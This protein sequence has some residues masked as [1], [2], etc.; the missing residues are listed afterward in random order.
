[1]ADEEMQERIS[2]FL[3]QHNTLTLASLHEGN[4]WACAV[5][6]CH[7]ET[8]NLYFISESKTW[9]AQDISAHPEVAVTIHGDVKSW[10]DIQ[11]LQ[12]TGRASLVPIDKRKEVEDLY[13][14]TFLDI[15]A[16]FHAARDGQA[17]KI[18]ERFRQSD[19][20]CIEPHWIRFIDNSRGFGFKEE[21]KLK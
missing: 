6:Y 20:Y 2:N 11:G 19:F 5:F 12:V 4:P 16:L 14:N 13:L 7:D 9:H 10:N 3:S 21:L 15:K 1:M 17:L 18:A 8:L